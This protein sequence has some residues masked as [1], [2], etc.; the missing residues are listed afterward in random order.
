[1]G[2]VRCWV[3][4]FLFVLW[5][6]VNVCWRFVVGVGSLL[7]GSLV[8]GG[9]VSWV[10][11]ILLFVGCCCWILVGCC[12]SCWCLVGCSLLRVGA[13]WVVVGLF[14]LAR[15]LLVVRSL[16]VVLV[17]VCR[18]FLLV[19]YVVVCWVV[20]GCCWFVVCGLWFVCWCVGC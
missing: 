12:F 8:C 18:L 17:D 9:G 13:G 15:V 4:I 3:L 20:R 2:F 10:I 1:M 6:F 5:V 19:F 7:F 14:V 16:L 11:V